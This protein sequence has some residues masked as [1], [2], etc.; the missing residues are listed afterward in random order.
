MAFHV[1]DIH[2]GLDRLKL[3]PILPPKL[4]E[5][6]NLLLLLAL[7]KDARADRQDGEA[8]AYIEYLCHNI[9]HGTFPFVHPGDTNQ[10]I[11][12]RYRGNGQDNNIASGAPVVDQPVF[13][14]EK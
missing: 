3:R 6:T 12:Q 2:V 11:H 4:V 10:D 1:N 13:R 14:R 7:G 5:D 9:E 8:E